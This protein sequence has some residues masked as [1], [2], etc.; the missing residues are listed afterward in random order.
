MELTTEK[1]L[2]G[3]AKTPKRVAVRKKASSDSTDCAAGK[4]G[5][6]NMPHEVRRLLIT[7]APPADESSSPYL[8]LKKNWGVEVE[9]FNLFRIEGCSVHEF[10]KQNINPLVY[11]AVIFTSKHAV[12]HFFRLCKELRIEMPAET[13]YF[14]ATDVIS[15]YLHKYIVIRKRKLFVAQNGIKDLLDLI[16][17]HNKET[18]FF[19]GGPETSRSD[20]CDYM[21]KANYK[22]KV[23]VVYQTVAEDLSKLRDKRYDMVCFFSS[24]GVETFK[25]RLPDFDFSRTLVGVFG[26]NSEQAALAAGMRVDVPAPRPEAPSMTNAIELFLK[27]N[28]P[29]QYKSD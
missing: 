3:A 27:E 1:E 25:S 7:H 22:Y 9:Y 11:K 24:A 8:I 2:E 13:K 5:T 4:P 17:K 15:K 26:A 28:Y 12:D 6:P 29:H 14:C 23:G 16:K 18:F 19:P 21:E 20:V 10:R